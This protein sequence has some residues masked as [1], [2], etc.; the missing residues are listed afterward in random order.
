[1]KRS[2][3]TL[4]HRILAFSRVVFTTIFLSSLLIII[5]GIYTTTQVKEDLEESLPPIG[6]LSDLED[7][8]ITTFLS[9][10]GSIIATLFEENYKPVAYENLG[11]QIVNAVV[12]IED[13]RF[14]SHNGVDYR[15]VARA[16]VQNTLAGEIQQGA[17]TITMQLARHL[18][19]SDERSYERKIREA[20]LARKLEKQY[21][22]SQILERYLNEVY[23]GGGAVGIGAASKRYFEKPP[24]DLKPEQA[25]LIAGLIQSPTHLNP[26]TNLRGARHR[27]VV[28]LTAMRDSGYLTGLEF[29]DALQRAREANFDNLSSTAGRPLLKY[30]YFSTVAMKQA[31]EEL[32]EERVYRTGLTVRTTVDLKAQKHLETTL[33][34]M[35]QQHG[36]SYNVHNGAA[37]LIENKTGH[38]KAIV[39]GRKWDSADRFNRATQALRQPGSTFKPILYAAAMERG[40]NQDTLVKDSASKWVIQDGPK[41]KVWSPHNADGRSRGEIPLREALRLSR[42]QASVYLAKQIGIWSLLDMA[43]RM[44]IE[45]ELPRVPSLALGTGEVTPLDMA[46]AYSVLPNHGMSREVTALTKVYSSEGVK[47]ADFAHGWTSLAVSPEVAEQVVDMMRRVVSSGTGRAAF[48]P[49]LQVAGKTGTTDSYKDA[50]FVGFTPKYTLAVWMGND[51][52][53]ATRYLYG[54]SLPAQTWKK[55]MAGLPQSQKQF[56]FFS[57]PAEKRVYCQKTHRLKGAGCQETY[58]E[59][60]RAHPPIT[61]RCT[62]CRVEIEP[63][64]YES[65]QF[66][67]PDPMN[68]D[69]SYP[70]SAPVIL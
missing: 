43:K 41:T 56:S 18:Y 51:D 14:F 45:T 25:A 46:K 7:R 54:G 68:I 67:M 4:R 66:E 48:I 19:L 3:H 58:T 11:Q 32:G 53:S 33:A 60:F 22:K 10:D 62:Q 49:G 28:V 13:A 50:W 20:L 23:F 63:E 15:S 27:Q 52:N 8:K 30:P 2:K 59:V 70:T 29:R 40:F 37:V 38:I 16:A 57:G 42:N 24:K 55:I 65:R 1:M 6:D 9:C 44:G 17:S 12:A 34:Q 69:P 26:L 35:L 64:G 39:G 21:S 5:G 47:V 31:I 36:R 61:S